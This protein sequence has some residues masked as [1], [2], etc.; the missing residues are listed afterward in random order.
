MTRS[1]IKELFPKPFL[2]FISLDIWLPAQSVCSQFDLNSN[3]ADTI[4]EK[5]K[6]QCYVRMN[7]IRKSKLWQIMIHCVKGKSLSA[8]R[9]SST[10][11]IKDKSIA[12]CVPVLRQNEHHRKS[13]L[14]QI[15]IHCVKGQKVMKETSSNCPCGSECKMVRF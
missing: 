15:M 10:L 11:C 5:H 1:V 6:R 9:Y 14:L 2:I 12:T 7:T 4:V 13:K 8:N 3:L